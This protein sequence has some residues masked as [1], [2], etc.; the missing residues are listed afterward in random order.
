MREKS[1]DL[2]VS[3]VN[4]MQRKGEGLWNQ[5]HLQPNSTAYWL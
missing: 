1:E 4:G 5:A 3:E 2:D